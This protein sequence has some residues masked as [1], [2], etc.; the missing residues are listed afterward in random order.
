MTYNVT[1]VAD[2]PGIVAIGKTETGAATD[3]GHTEV[4]TE[5]GQVTINLS[6]KTP[7]AESSYFYQKLTYLTSTTGSITINSGRHTI[8]QPG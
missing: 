1:I 4:F 3:I 5:A 2:G 6:G 7:I 8:T